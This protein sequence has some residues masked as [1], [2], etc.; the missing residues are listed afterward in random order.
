MP[1]I[2]IKRQNN[3]RNGT[4]AKNEKGDQKVSNKLVCLFIIAEWRV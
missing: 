3:D 4:G 1:G 2:V